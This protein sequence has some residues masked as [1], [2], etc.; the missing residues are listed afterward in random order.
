[1]GQEQPVCDICRL[2]P[3]YSEIIGIKREKS[4]WKLSGRDLRKQW[5]LSW[6]RRGLMEEKNV[7]SEDFPVGLVARTLDSQCRG[8]LDSIPW[9]G[10]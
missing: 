7:T 8:P 10:N 4:S 6:V 5:D 9:W 3:E 2:S 1:M